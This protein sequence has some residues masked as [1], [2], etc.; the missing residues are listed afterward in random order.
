MRIRF[1]PLRDLREVMNRKLLIMTEFGVRFEDEDPA[2]ELMYFSD[3]AHQ[4]R[5]ERREAAKK[6]HVFI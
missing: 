2:A 5:K 1:F 6:G 4:R 3:V